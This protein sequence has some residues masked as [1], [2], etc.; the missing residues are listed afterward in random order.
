MKYT[1][2][3]IGIL[4]LSVMTYGNKSDNNITQQ[5]A[6]KVI[7]IENLSWHTNIK[8]AFKLAKVQDKNVIIMVGED[9]CRW[10]VKMKENTLTDKR[11]QEHMQEYILISIKRSDKE[12]IKYVPEFDGNIPS[13]FF[14]TNSEEMIE[15][16]VGY[17]NS[18]DFL[19]YIQEIEEM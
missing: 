3:F 16:I 2:V 1:F 10:C 4:L 18:N 11:I 5:S 19:Q 12:S 15:P 9:D 6:D 17:F 8:E 7:K 14:M 13:F